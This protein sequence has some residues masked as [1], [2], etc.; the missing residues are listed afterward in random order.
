MAASTDSQTV[1]QK[2]Y[3]SAARWDDQRVVSKVDQ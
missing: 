3:Q 1:D 2:V